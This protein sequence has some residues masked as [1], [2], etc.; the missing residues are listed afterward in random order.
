MRYYVYTLSGPDG[1]VFYVG[2]GQG[3]R[4]FEHEKE[5]RRGH[6]CHKCYKIR[7]IWRAGGEVKR[8]IVFTTPIE[9]A[10][11]NYEAE[12]IG[13][14]GLKNLTN[15]APG[16]IVVEPRIYPRPDKPLDEYTDQEYRGF[17]DSLGLSRRQRNER[18][19]NWRASTYKYLRTQWAYWRRRQ[20][21]DKA[22]Q[23]M[24][25]LQELADALGWV[26]QDGLGI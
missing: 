19:R 26:D 10:A 22:D 12:L 24:A 21:N 3:R 9:A 11:Y 25:R 1:V 16:M 4:M 6:R 2:K 7:K 17:L 14:I 5:A 20:M 18:L 8:A 15:A 23:V 13:H